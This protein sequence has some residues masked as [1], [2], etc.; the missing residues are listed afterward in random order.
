[1]SNTLIGKVL[2]SLKR[3]SRDGRGR[4]H[5]PVLW[6]T[7]LNLMD[8]GYISEN[9][10]FYDAELVSEFKRI[11]PQYALAD[12]LEQPSQPYFHL[13]SSEIWHH[14]VKEDAAVYYASLTTSGGGSKRIHE[15]IEYAF[16]DP[17]IYEDLLVEENREKLQRAIVQLLQDEARGV[18]VSKRIG[19]LFHESF[20]LSR[21][22][23]AAVLRQAGKTDGLKGL[24]EQLQEEE[25]LGKN[26]AKAVPAYARGSGFLH[27]NSTELTPLGMRVREHDPDL[28][29]PATQWLMH[30][31]LSASH[32]PGPRFWHELVRQMPEW[33]QP[34]GKGEVVAQI[35]QTTREESGTALKER[36]VETTATVFL[37]SYTKPDA[38]GALGILS[39]EGE[40]Y[41]VQS[42]DAPPLGVLA[43]A[44]SHYWQGQM[45]IK[46]TCNMDDLSVPGGFG[47]LFFM[48][49]F[50]VNRAL[51]Q[52]AR[53]GLLE[54]WMAAPPYQVTR[55]PT[56]DKLLEGIY[57]AE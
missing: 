14:R 13:R 34:F 41:T 10:I 21:P 35:G 40:G 46:H 29:L 25:K 47:S 31:H 11:F 50:G 7:V 44:L 33:P 16:L 39:D 45:G 36:G 28:S 49:S 37:G 27:F 17:D 4:P 23:V 15:S 30:Y 19:T 2:S 51:R 56:P 55:P 3:G 48:G 32:G 42:P 6:L 24:V 57:A 8:R 26:W 52:M 20:A 18:E 12:D 54:L 9:K 5:K 1:M 22:G 43:Y 38:L 53:Q